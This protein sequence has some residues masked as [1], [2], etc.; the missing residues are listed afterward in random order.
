[1]S[2][3]NNECS[4]PWETK[5]GICRYTLDFHGNGIHMEWPQTI[6]TQPEWSVFAGK[7]ASINKHSQAAAS[8]LIQ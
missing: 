7:A 6:P 5:G 1:M 3:E 2:Q 8:K 4:K